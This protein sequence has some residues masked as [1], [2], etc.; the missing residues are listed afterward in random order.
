MKRVCVYC[1]SRE[2]ARPAYSAMA[3]R[4]GELLAGK[5]IG[6]V[7]GGMRAGLMG[8]VADAV[9]DGGGEVIGIIPEILAEQGL[10][11][12][13]VRDL[14]TVSSMPARKGMMA[15]LA[16]AF[17][18]LP[19]GVGTWEEFFE[20]WSWATLGLHDKPCGIL[21]VEGYYDRLIEFL[22]QAVAEEFL[23]EKNRAMVLVD[24]SPER[25]LDRLARFGKEN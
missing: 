13:R 6:L 3:R 20:I 8:E 16:D 9:L 14:R 25:L 10:G 21:N 15:E 22:D 19:G 23:K 24:D 1:G 17:I 4:L 2:G 7:Y 11:H 18:V 12:P 5:G